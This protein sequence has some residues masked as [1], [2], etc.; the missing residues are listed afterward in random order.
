VGKEL[1]ANALH[2]LS[3][4][5]NGPL[6]KVH[7][8]AFASSLLESELF[9]H[10][11]GAFTG[12][13][14]RRRGRFELANEG[15]LFLDEIG[16]VD[17]NIQ[18]KLLRVLQE[19]K[20]ERLGGEETIDVDVRIVT[21]TNKDLKAEIEKGTFREDLYYRLNVVNITVPPLR[22]RKDDL[23]LLIRE[24]IVQS[25][26]ENGKQVTGIDEK[27]RSVLF[28]YD[29]PGNIR[30]LKNCIES[31]VVMCR[32][33]VITKNDLPP[34]LGGNPSNDD[35]TITISLGTRLE[36]AEGK[37]IRETLRFQKGN[38]SRTA[39]V[40]GIGRK[41]LDRKLAVPPAE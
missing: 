23:P 31:T 19:K 3:P 11:K 40:L 7:C 10:E 6:I 14:S 12:A 35:N 17:Q 39:E 18:I 8:A 29:W 38:K 9:G 25:A 27:A 33:T 22:E 26:Q 24:F 20:F 21:A 16:E 34:S 5:K 37:I 36:E 28:N 41:T 15:T 1:V 13:L 2:E 4:R 32:G 30:E